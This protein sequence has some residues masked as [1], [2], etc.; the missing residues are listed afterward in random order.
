M[1][2]E[3]RWRHNGGTNGTKH[4]PTDRLGLHGQRFSL[5]SRCFSTRRTTQSLTQQRARSENAEGCPS[6]APQPP[7]ATPFD[8]HDLRRQREQSA[9]LV[10][11]S[12]SAT[13]PRA[14]SCRPTPT[15][16][17]ASSLSGRVGEQGPLSGHRARSPSE[18]RRLCAGGSRCR[19]SRTT[20]AEAGKPSIF[21]MHPSSVAVSQARRARRPSG[22]REKGRCTEHCGRLVSTQHKHGEQESHHASWQAGCREVQPVGRTSRG[23]QQATSELTCS[24]PATLSVAAACARKKEM[25]SFAFI[26]GS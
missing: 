26:T 25:R 23:P 13:V 11:A 17:G 10:R 24:P 1:I 12:A 16:T 6:S 8:H 9:R 22:E 21:P 20:P 7:S 15:L 14:A 3:K 2:A 4:G 18:R 19:C 5:A